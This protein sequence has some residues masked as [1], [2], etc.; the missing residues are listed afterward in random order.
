MKIVMITQGISGVLNELTGSGHEII[1]IVEACP[2]KKK[3]TLR[4][5][6]GYFKNLK[7]FALPV[8]QENIL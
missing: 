7:T 5:L 8:S 1:G 2:R 6:L 4:W 3:S